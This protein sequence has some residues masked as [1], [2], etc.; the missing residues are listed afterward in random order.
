MKKA[1]TVKL[2]SAEG[3]EFIVDQRAASVSNT[4]KNMLSS[5]GAF[6]E[7]E[8]GEV[9]FPEITTEVLEKICQYFYYK[10]RY[11]NSTS[12]IPEFAIAPEQALS[13]LMSANFLDC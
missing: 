13:L 1:E 5:Q 7:T 9:K 6:T 11:T 8:L 2:I 12:Q 4:I 3:F 10:L